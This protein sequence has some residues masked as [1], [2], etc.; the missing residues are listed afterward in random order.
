MSS[1]ASSGKRTVVFAAHWR[2]SIS[3]WSSG[4]AAFGI[5]AS[6]AMPVF[7]T[8]APAALSNVKFSGVPMVDFPD[9]ANKPG[10]LPYSLTVMVTVEPNG[11]VKIDKEGE[12][13]KDFLKKVKDASKHWKTTAPRADGKPVTVRFPLT[14]T[15]QR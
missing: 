10:K 2:P 3:F 15:F 14:I 13:D 5:A 6:A 11:N 4:N 9:V 7:V 1:F 8:L 12:G